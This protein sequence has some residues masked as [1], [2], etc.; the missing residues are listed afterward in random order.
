VDLAVRM[1]DPE[2]MHTLAVARYIV[3]VDSMAEELVVV[4]IT[5]IGHNR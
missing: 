1:V 5:L 2:K 3:Q 4:V